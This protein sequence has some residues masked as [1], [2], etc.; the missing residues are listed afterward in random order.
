MVLASPFCRTKETARL[1]FGRATV[2][3]ALL[4]TVSAVHDARWRRQIRNARRLL[5][6]RPD[7]GRITVLV[8]HGSVVA[9]ATGETLEEGEALVFRPHGSSRF[10]LLGRILPREWRT[11]RARS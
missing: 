6:A 8:T 3:R 5:G 4:N 9:D 10:T 7:A 1:A 2:S 11:L